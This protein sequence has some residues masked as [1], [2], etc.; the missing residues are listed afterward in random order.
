MKF[1]Q[2]PN[3]FVSHVQ[4]IVEQLER[5]LSFYQGILGFQIL[6]RTDSTA[7]LTLNEKDALVTLEQPAGVL[8]KEPRRSGLYHYAI[9]V[10][11][12]KELAKVIQHFIDIKYP[13]QGI[14]DH[15]VSEALYLADPDGNGIEI[16]VD[17]PS[18]DWE[19][20][21][22]QVTMSTE[23]VNLRSLLSE[24]NG[25]RFTGL[26]SD[27]IM[28]HIHL[29][30]S[31]LAKA[32]EFYIQGLGFKVVYQI[33]NQA[34]FI[35]TGGYHHH[36]GLNIWNGKG[37]QAPS[38]NSVGLKFYTIVFTDEMTRDSAIKNLALLGYSVN[39]NTVVDPSGNHILLKY[40]EL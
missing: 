13:L 30:V 34:L 12:R 1:H 32:A 20:I 8:P 7:S 33:S 27:T 18:E 22:E 10:P 39:E 26:S 38:R 5:S 24:A 14:S 37:V 29:H 40:Q 11:D 16:Y 21:G 23:Q 31:D 36:I 25:E 17:R 28:G 15:L 2:Q 9:L 6:D 35:S 19:W 4:L 3:T